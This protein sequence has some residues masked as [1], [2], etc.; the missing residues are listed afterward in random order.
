MFYVLRKCSFSAQ[1][2]PYESFPELQAAAA[3]E[4][5]GTVLV[6]QGANVT[7]GP[8]KNA[9]GNQIG[10]WHAPPFAM[11]YP[12]HLT[13]YTGPCETLDDM[14]AA[15]ALEVPGAKLVPPARHLLKSEHTGNVTDSQGRIV[16]QWYEGR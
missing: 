8:I 12:V 3:R 5:P 11:Q 10:T 7:Q 16:G 13:A 2:G 9:A 6:T 15:I 4:I 1:L 14:E